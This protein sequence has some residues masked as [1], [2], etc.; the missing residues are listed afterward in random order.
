MDFRLKRRKKD[1]K[2]NDHRIDTGQK[3]SPSSHILS[4]AC[5]GMNLRAGQIRHSFKGGVKDL[6]QPN[7]ANGDR[8]QCPILTI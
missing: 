7:D 3:H 2:A 4:D 8:Y 1:E 6:S 5:Q